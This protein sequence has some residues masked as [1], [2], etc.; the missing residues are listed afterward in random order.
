MYKIGDFSKLCRVP[1]SALRYYADLGL[2]E[3][4]HIDRFTG[5]RYYTLEQLPRLNR[6]LALKDFGLSLSQI[7]QFMDESVSPEELR[8]ML[9]LRQSEVQQ[10]L[11]DEQARLARIEARLR[12]IEL[13]GKMPEREVVLKSIEPQKVLSVREIIPTPGDVATLMTEFFM[14]SM[15]DGVEVIGPPI[16]IFHDPEFKPENLDVEI[17]F[18]VGDSAPASVAL[19]A[20]RTASVRILPR[21]ESAACVIHKGSFDLLTEVYGGLGRWIMESGY[22]PAGASREVYLQAPDE[23]QEPIT[24][25]QFP[26]EKV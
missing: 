18:P 12:L 6:I 3:P 23:G 5:Y 20:G 7:A 17:A 10:Q 16:A 8:G 22:R 1:V 15:R 26:V 13:E 24:E 11:E 14:A 9:R 21:I 25:I 4:A 19:D 2:L